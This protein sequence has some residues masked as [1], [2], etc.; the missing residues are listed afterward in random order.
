MKLIPTCKEVHRLT[1]ESMD[2]ELRLPERVRMRAHLK[3]C[4]ACQNFTG[5]MAFIRRAIRS[6]AW[7]DGSAGGTGSRPDQP[8]T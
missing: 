5:Q 1:S 6:M 4:R 7:E 3:W 2:R 8:E